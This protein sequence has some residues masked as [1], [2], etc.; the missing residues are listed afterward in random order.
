MFPF[1]FSG[2]MTFISII[3]TGLY[4][5][6]IVIIIIII[7]ISI[8]TIIDAMELCVNDCN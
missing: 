6:F 7:K 2:S 4:T 1:G 3:V 5:V 8:I